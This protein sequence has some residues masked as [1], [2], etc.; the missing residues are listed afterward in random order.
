MVL[1]LLTLLPAAGGGDPRVDVGDSNLT[2]YFRMETAKLA[3]SALAEPPTDPAAWREEHRHQLFEMLGLSPLPEWTP[4]E[5]VVTGRV[6]ADDFTVENLHFQ[7]MAGLY[8]TANLYI[9]VG[10][11]APAP[12]IL[13]VCGHGASIQDGVSY[14]NK[15]SYHHHGAWF[16]RHGYV[17]LTIDTLQLGEIQGLHHG[18]HRLG[19]WW[20]NSRGYTPAGVE[21]WNGIRAVDYLVSRSEV[22]PKRIGMTG[23]SGGGAYTWFVAALD[24]RIRVAAPVAGITDLE[25]HVVDGVVEGH[26]DC[27]FFVN[28]YRWD[29]PLLA[30]LVAPRPLLIANSDKDSIFPLEGVLRVHEKVR[31]VYRS[32]GAANHLGLLITEGPHR[33]SQD[34][35]VPVFRWFNRFLQQDDALIERAAMR[36]FEPEQL[37]VFDHLP[38]D[39]R[40]ADI[41]ETFVAGA[42]GPRIPDSANDWKGMRDGW[43]SS[44]RKLSF[45]AWPQNS[46]PVRVSL[47]ATGKGAGLGWRT[48]EI[49]SQPAVPLRLIVLRQQDADFPRQVMLHVLDDAQWAQWTPAMRALLSLNPDAAEA[50]IDDE[51]A[52]LLQRGAGREP[53][54]LA[55][56]APRGVGPLAWTVPEA[57][58]VQI[59]RRFQL[60]GQTVDGM[61]VWDIMRGIQAVQSIVG[62]GQLPVHLR[63]SD[64]MAVNA[65]MASL[66]E[67]GLHRLELIR[68]P[69]SFRHGPDYLNVLRILELPEALAMATPAAGVRLIEPAPGVW[70]YSFMVG[71]RLDWP[72]DRIQFGIDLR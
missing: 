35:R 40:N 21:A 64:D 26:C 49:E 57:K 43:L 54:L 45:A 51:D 70:D 5:A 72:R 31:T 4:L 37:K 3:A 52:M 25:N 44:L 13:Y 42:P 48:Y 8:V 50:A 41:Q 12:A 68:L 46:P 62:Q 22:D 55:W 67:P 34:L 71:T 38:L 6:V 18:T 16:A 60:L 39:A 27:M 56:L 20:W 30:A 29:Y 10:L 32:L 53:G 15:V 36:V 59:R 63:A 19:Q 14:G 9:P 65:L 11:Q 58:Q 69:A 66:F 23:R 47:T 7:S 61:R 33:D 24:E 1:G 17:C 28:T 2:E